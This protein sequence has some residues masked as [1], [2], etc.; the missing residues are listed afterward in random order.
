[1]RTCKNVR[2]IDP[3]IKLC[4]PCNTWFKEQ[5]KRLSSH[6]RQQTAREEV[7]NQN[8][9]LNSPGSSQPSSMTGA[10]AA[11]PPASSPLTAGSPPPQTIDI[12]SIQDTYNQLKH[13]STESPATLNMYALMLNIHSK[14]LLLQPYLYLLCLVE[15]NTVQ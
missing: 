10:N 7:Q 6:E 11:P 13:S 1:M 4:P 5:T 8:R 9:N 14:D 3:I 12:K 15:S 2:E